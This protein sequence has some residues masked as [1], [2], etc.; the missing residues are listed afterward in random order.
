[1]CLEIINDGKLRTFEY[2]HKFHR[3]CIA[4]WFKKTSCPFC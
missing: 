1:M 3:E 2:G 4:K